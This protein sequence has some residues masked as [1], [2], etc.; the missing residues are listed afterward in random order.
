V[1]GKINTCSKDD[2]V[3]GHAQPSAF[4]HFDYMLAL[5][6]WRGKAQGAKVRA[7]RDHWIP[8]HFG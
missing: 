5:L 8:G 4:K 1:Q 3:Q 7:F 2:P 6:P